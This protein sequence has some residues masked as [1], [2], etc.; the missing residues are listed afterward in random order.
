MET[1]EVIKVLVDSGGT[2]LFAAISWYLFRDGKAKDKKLEESH[3]ARVSDAKATTNLFIKLKENDS[4]I[5]NG[6][7]CSPRSDEPD[8]GR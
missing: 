8:S 4:G 1:V 6:G 7:Q 5:R 3:K 2:V